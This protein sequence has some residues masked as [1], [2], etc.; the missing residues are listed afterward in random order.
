LTITYPDGETV[1]HLFDQQGRLI[2]SQNAQTT[3]DAHYDSLGR[4][5][6]LQSPGGRTL[7]FRYDN[8]GRLQALTDETGKEVQH[9]AVSLRVSDAGRLVSLE[10]PLGKMHLRRDEAG[11]LNSIA[12]D[13]GWKAVV[14]W[15]T[16]T[17]RPRSMV[18]PW[19][20]VE[21]DAQGRPRE[22]FTPQGL[23]ASAAW[24]SAGQLEQVT[25]P[26]LGGV[27]IG[28]DASR[29]PATIQFPDGLRIA[30][31][32]E[33]AQRPA[34]TVNAHGA[35][36]FQQ[37]SAEKLRRITESKPDFPRQPLSGRMLDQG[38]GYQFRYSVPPLNAGNLLSAHRDRFWSRV[39]SLVES[40]AK[41]PMPSEEQMRRHEEYW[42]K[43]EYWTADPYYA[44]LAGPMPELSPQNYLKAFGLTVGIIATDSA[45]FFVDILPGIN[46]WLGFAASEAL[47]PPRR[48]MREQLGKADP[49][50]DI[51]GGLDNAGDRLR[52]W[53][54]VVGMLRDA[55]SSIL[56]R[57]Q[58]R[59]WAARLDYLESESHT[60]LLL[61]PERMWAET[62]RRTLH[63]RLLATGYT[64][65][66][67]WPGAGMDAAGIAAR[68][69]IGDQLDGK[70]LGKYAGSPGDDK[71]KAVPLRI[72]ARSARVTPMPE[73]QLPELLSDRQ[74]ASQ[75]EVVL[76]PHLPSLLLPPNP[77]AK[78]AR[79]GV[80]ILRK[81]YEVK[82]ED[83]PVNPAL[84]KTRDVILNKCPPGQ[85]VCKDGPLL[86]GSDEP[87]Q[88]RKSK[89]DAK[90]KPK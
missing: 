87:E 71:L 40:S 83:A 70:I 57:T 7:G 29:A 78:D 2:L 37:D 35:S 31:P 86:G 47:M 24:N 14:R 30:L 68:K 90:R 85:V 32:R 69:W 63:V 62:Y 41:I 39:A 6:R 18:A 23:R 19:G 25:M 81:A 36:A 67:D 46:N 16:Q 50:N 4:L 52:R 61:T 10:D 20:Y 54:G 12:S 72:D 38:R 89:T 1:S 77:G 75:R 21:F 76:K 42:T 80:V 66:F 48:W 82:P 44:D 79:S 9:W 34:R 8:T 5:E 74:E 59:P 88:G 84:E 53:G 22:M 58:L 73:I 49:G 51:G 65:G 13:W 60:L 15:D 43:G 45:R 3:L 27:R 28:Y 55:Y 26:L 64:V 33:Q 56:N 17:N 11:R